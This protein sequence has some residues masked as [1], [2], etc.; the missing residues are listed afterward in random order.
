MGY[1]C[2][3]VSEHDRFCGYGVPTICEHP[4]C[5]EEIDRGLAHACGDEPGGR[6]AGCGL[7]FCSKHLPGYRKPRG[8]WRYRQ[9]CHRCTAYRNPFPVK[10]ELKRWMR[11]ILTDGSWAEW[12]KEYPKDAEAYRAAVFGDRCAVI[13]ATITKATIRSA[14]RRHTRKA[15]V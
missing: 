13:F 7:Y 6:E 15:K 12:R 8:D 5:N 1:A 4:K 14:V 3:H 11:W 10:P 9:L 2:Y